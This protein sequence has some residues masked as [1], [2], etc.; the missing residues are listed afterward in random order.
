MQTT[1]TPVISINPTQPTMTPEIPLDPTNPL[2][3][4]LILATL[5]TASEKPLNAIANLLR[6]IDTFTKSRKK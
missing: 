6:A 5:L 1:T 3:W 4:L 2:V